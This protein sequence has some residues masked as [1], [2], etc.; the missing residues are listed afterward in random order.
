[1]IDQVG[2]PKAGIKLTPNTIANRIRYSV[3]AE[4][5]SEP[6]GQLAPDK[7][8]EHVH[9]GLAG[10][11]AGKRGEPLTPWRQELL[12]AADRQ[13]FKRLQAVRGKSRGSDGKPLGAARCFVGEDLFGGRLEP[14]GRPEP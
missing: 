3:T 14:L 13:L 12:A 5:K 9:A 11:E 4:A 10:I 2:G 6:A 7:G 1:M 8:F